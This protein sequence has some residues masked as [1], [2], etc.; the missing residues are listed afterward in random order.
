MSDTQNTPL[1][2]Q[3]LKRAQRLS[4]AGATRTSLGFRASLESSKRRSTLLMTPALNKRQ[5]VVPNPGSGSTG[6]FSALQNL[7]PSQASQNSQLSQSSQFSQSSFPKKGDQRPLRDRNY[8]ALILQEIYDFLVANKFELEMNHPI[9][10]KMLRQPTQKDFVLMFQ[11]LYSRIDP[12]YRFT[13]SVES[14]VFVLLKVL[15]YPYLEG[16]NR[17]SISAVGLNWPAFLGML[18]WLV[19]LNLSLLHLSEDALLAPDDV[20][21]RVFIKY[22]ISSYRAFIDQKEDYAEFYDE[23]KRNFDVAN[24]EVLAA[25]DEKKRAGE[26]LVREFDELNRQYQHIEEAEA[27]SKALENDLREFSAYIAELKERQTRWSGRLDEM[28]QEITNA[29]LNLRELA[30]EKSTLENGITNRGYSIQQIDK[31][32]QERDKLSKTIDSVSNR[33]EDIRETMVNKDNELRQIYQSLES[34]VSQYNLM[35]LRVP[36]GGEEYELALNPNLLE[37]DA[38]AIEP[39]DVL[40]KPLPQEKIRLLEC[41]HELKQEVHKVQEDSIKLIEQVDQFSEKI[42]EQQEEIEAIEAAVE[43]NRLTHTEIYENLLSEGT[44]YSAQIEKLDRELQAMRISANRGLFEAEAELKKR[45]F[46]HEE[47]KY[48]IKNQREVLHSTV[49]KLI[50]YIIS[51]KL[52]VQ[53]NIEDLDNQMLK[54]LENEEKAR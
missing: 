52:N 28:Q 44:S 35:T 54:E 36:S 34:F 21:D 29:E 50:D 27:K 46:D 10:A 17:S 12:H 11:F 38:V 26:L 20:F 14:E 22:I 5:S 51:F 33:I 8:Q 40:S 39:K 9:A 19:K 49:Q 4:I 1:A 43:K 48:R 6:P 13:R 47:W 31:L 24:D 41:R 16:I 45:K 18:Y 3:L 30:T 2:A 42:F 32:N 7:Q 37:S 23:M 15:S 53:E 25:S